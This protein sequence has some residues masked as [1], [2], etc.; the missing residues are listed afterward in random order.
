MGASAPKAQERQYP[1]IFTNNNNQ[2]AALRA[3]RAQSLLEKCSHHEQGRHLNL[4]APFLPDCKLR[5]RHFS[6]LE[7]ARLWLRNSVH[8][9]LG[10]PF[11]PDWELRG[12][13]F[14][15]QRA[16]VFLLRDSGAAFAS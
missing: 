15:V 3:N 8:L 7:G 9:H 4:W 6:G 5:G 14:Q 12:R 13:L 11:S 16:P 2:R 1:S 10:A